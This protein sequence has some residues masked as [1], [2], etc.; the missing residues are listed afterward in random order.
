MQD[1]IERFVAREKPPKSEV[2]DM[3]SLEA[4]PD[5][6]NG[7]ALRDYQVSPWVSERWRLE[8]FGKVMIPLYVSSLPC[9]DPASKSGNAAWRSPLNSNCGPLVLIRAAT[10]SF[11]PHWSQQS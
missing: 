3:P 9:S 1:H 10:I 6:Q 5:F 2:E 4:V 8:L 7:R 11:L